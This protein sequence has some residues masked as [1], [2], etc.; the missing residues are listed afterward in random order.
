MYREKAYLDVAHVAVCS[1]ANAKI[2]QCLYYLFDFGEFF[3]VL[4]LHI[5]IVIAVI[6]D[7]I[8]SLASVVVLIFFQFSN[9][10]T[11]DF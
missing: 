2:Q 4:F 7:L 11:E 5:R 1:C 6:V 10:I 8:I 3:V 9:V